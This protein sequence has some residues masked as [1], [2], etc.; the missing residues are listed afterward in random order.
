M[1]YSAEK[2]EAKHHRQTS[3][4]QKRVSLQIPRL[5]QPQRTAKNFRRAVKPAHAKARNDP[6][7]ETVSESGNEIVQFN[8]RGFVKFI[9]VKAVSHR[10]RKLTDHLRQRVGR[11][12]GVK[13][14]C[15]TEANHDGE[16]AKPRTQWRVIEGR[17][18]LFVPR[19]LMNF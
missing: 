13:L 15:N 6:A 7:V 14:I 10:A 11:G 1:T 9:E 8:D 12:V 18:K 4:E 19:D 3:N 17:E 2:N 16:Q 5:H